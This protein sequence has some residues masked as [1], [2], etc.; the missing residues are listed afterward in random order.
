MPYRVEYRAARAKSK[1][2]VGDFPEGHH[3]DEDDVAEKIIHIPAAT[4]AGLRVKAEVLFHK[5]GLLR[6]RWE[7]PDEWEYMLIGEGILLSAIEDI[8][9]TAAFEEAAS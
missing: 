4:A 6:C 2:H 8:L 5:S 7:K 9:R 1:A 3:F